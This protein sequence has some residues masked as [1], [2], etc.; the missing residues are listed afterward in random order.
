MRGFGIDRFCDCVW[1]CVLLTFILCDRMNA[2][3]TFCRGVFS[4]LFS[5]LLYILCVLLLM[6]SWTS[7]SS[8][9]C[10]FSYIFVSKIV[11]YQ[12][13]ITWKWYTI[14]MQRIDSHIIFSV[15]EATAARI[16]MLAHRY[17]IPES[18]E[19]KRNETEL[20]VCV[21]SDRL[22]ATMPLNDNI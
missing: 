3:C 22:N 14:H 4:A 7:S 20:S 13:Y 8:S 16:H 18:N 11:H 12:Y 21:I 6:S 2:F 19:T 15:I 10:E 17:I 9:C 1:V 5:S